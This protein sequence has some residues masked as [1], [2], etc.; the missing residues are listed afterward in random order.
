VTILF[1]Y[2]TIKNSVGNVVE[3][4]NALDADKYTR[5]ELEENYLALKE[6]WGEW[7]IFGEDG[8]GISVKYI[9][10]GNAL[11]SG[12]MITFSVF[13]IIFLLLAII[14]GKILMPMLIKMYKES[15]EQLV[16]IATLKTMEQVN[17]LSGKK[18]K[19]KKPKKE[20]F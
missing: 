19:N 18:E 6:K 17:E 3:I 7:V 16:D 5:P 20:W 12:L 4:I 13:T 8:A 15:N 14:I 1:F 2:L 9:N 10:I 11:F